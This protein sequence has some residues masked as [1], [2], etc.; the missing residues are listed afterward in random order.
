MSSSKFYFCLY[1]STITSTLCV[2]HAE[3]QSAHDS[4]RNL[5]ILCAYVTKYKLFMPVQGVQ[6]F[7]DAYCD[8]LGNNIMLQSAR[9]V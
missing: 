8:L 9:W 3:L 6:V 1:W 2:A 4:L 7:T 5:F